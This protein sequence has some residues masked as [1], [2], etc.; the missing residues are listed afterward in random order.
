MDRRS[1]LSASLA[2]SALSFATAGDLSAQA[3]SDAD[4]SAPQ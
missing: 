2:A 1:F 3:G 4:K